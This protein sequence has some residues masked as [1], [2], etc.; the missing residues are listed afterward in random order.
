MQTKHNNPPKW[1]H[2]R[3]R[4]RGLALVLAATACL[5]AFSEPSS[6]SGGRPRQ[7]GNHSSHGEQGGSGGGQGFRNRGG[8]GGGMMRGPGGGGRGGQGGG[9][10]RPGGGGRGGQGGGMMRGP[11]GGR[12]AAGAVS[13]QPDDIR[14]SA[15]ELKALFDADK[16]GVLSDDERAKMAAEMARAE[17]LQR[18]LLPWKVIRKVDTDGDLEISD[19]EA[20]SISDALEKLRPASSTG[21]SGPSG[22]MRGPGGGGRGGQGG[23]MRGLGGDGRGGQGG[24]MRRPGGQSSAEPPKELVE[25]PNLRREE[26]VSQN[27]K[28]NYCEFLENAD[29][30]GETWRVLVF[31]GMSARGDDNM[32]QLSSPSIKPLLDY[33]RQEKIKTL[34]LVPQCPADA[35]WA[36]GGEKPVLDLVHELAEA[37]R[38][39]YSV[40]PER[41]IATGFSMGAGG[42]YFLL[43]KHPGEFTRAIVVGAGGMESWAQKLRG[44]F[45]IA[46]GTED[47]FSSADN[48]EVL[49]RAI[50]DRGNVVHFEKLA[51][52]DHLQSAEKVYGGDC[53]EWAFAENP[54]GGE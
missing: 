8:Q 44:A 29:A 10:R 33:V 26:F 5:C 34:V 27:G 46:T 7:R 48:A 16:N 18:F 47:Q 25:D 49:A 21:R 53:W 28:L 50:A 52:A 35:S 17:V 23:G 9:M 20:E 1:Q 14:T 2:E 41:S 24:G 30:K 4:L 3:F 6:A 12:P 11:G 45:Y 40:A 38:R 15:D 31:H 13:M 19:K 39:E 37:K 42:C 43:M 54:D 22:G 36:R 32:R 51:G